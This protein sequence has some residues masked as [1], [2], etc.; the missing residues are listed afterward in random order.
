MT[1]LKVS[2]WGNVYKPGKFL[3]K[4]QTILI[5]LVHTELKAQVRPTT[6]E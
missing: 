5:I 4:R 1:F 3:D 2:M 6:R